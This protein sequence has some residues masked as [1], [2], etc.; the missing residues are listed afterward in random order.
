MRKHKQYIQEWKSVNDDIKELATKLVDIMWYK[1]YEDK[2]YLDVDIKIPY[3][4]GEFPLYMETVF[5]DGKEHFGLDK[6][7]VFYKIFLFDSI[8]QYNMVYNRIGNSEYNVGENKLFIIDGIIGGEYNYSLVENV[9]HELSHAFEYGMGMEKREDLYDKVADLIGKGSEVE[10]AMC[11]MVYYTFSH[12]QDAFAHQF[13]GRLTSMNEEATFE[14][15]LNSFPNYIDFM[16]SIMI[17][18]KAVSEGNEEVRGCLNYLGMTS[19]KF[20][21][22]YRFGKN[23]LVRKLRN[24]YERYCMEKQEK[25]M[26]IEGKINSEFV[27]KQILEN[28]RERYKDIEYR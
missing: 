13:Y 9:Y 21:K 14:E 17:Y 25:S 27:S 5:N 24:V 3:V 11:K 6:I 12:E 4:S 20:N 1:S 16:R 19:E 26:T 8:E 18:T 10:V 22:R 2:P 23:R 28:Y 15:Y 7:N